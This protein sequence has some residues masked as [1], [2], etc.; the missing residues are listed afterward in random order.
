M[1]KV[2][3]Q[4]NFLSP[5]QCQKL[6]QFYNSTPQ[7]KQYDTTFPLSITN[8]AP[9]Y[10]KNKV[11][12][13][14]I[15]INNS[16]IDWFE[17]VKWPTPNRGKQLHSD[18]A[19]NRTSLSSIIYLN[20]NYEGGHTFFEDGTSFAPVEGRAIF[21]DGKYYRHGVS[22]ISNGTRYTVASWLKKRG[23]G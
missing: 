6:I 20:N 22:S 15:A 3:L 14:G 1:F 7:P 17:I 18:D 8:I 16:V 5:L 4:D 11:N 10:L 13:T 2:I 12:K 9:K 19:S 21:F 23:D